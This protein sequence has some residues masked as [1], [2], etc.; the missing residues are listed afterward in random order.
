MKKMMTL[1]AAV[2]LLALCL[3]GCGDDGTY[4]NGAYAIPDELQA[5]YDGFIG[6]IDTDY[7]YEIAY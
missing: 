5:R 3:T 2:L 4:D 1:L 7:G 6:N